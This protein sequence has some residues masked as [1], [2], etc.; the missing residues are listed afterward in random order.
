MSVVHHPVSTTK[1]LPYYLAI[2]PCHMAS[3]ALLGP[4]H[5]E[6]TVYSKDIILLID[7]VSDS[8]Q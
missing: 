3:L 8:M 5:G 4:R 2:G 7:H 1:L 6:L